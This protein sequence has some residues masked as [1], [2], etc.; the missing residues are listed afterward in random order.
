MLSLLPLLLAAL[1]LSPGLACFLPSGQAG[2][3]GLDGNCYVCPAGSM[4]QD[5]VR[6]FCRTVDGE[7]QPYSGQTECLMS[8]VCTIEQY[9]QQKTTLRTPRICANLTHCDS[10]VSYVAVNATATTDRVCQCSDGHADSYPSCPPCPAGCA[11]CVLRAEGVACSLCAAALVL[12]NETC[13]PLPSQGFTIRENLGAVLAVSIVCVLLVAVTV[14]AVTVVRRRRISAAATA[15]AREQRRIP[16]D[17]FGQGP[18]Y[19]TVT[20]PLSAPPLPPPRAEA[21]YV[22]PTRMEMTH[23]YDLATETSIYDNTNTPDGDGYLDVCPTDE[24]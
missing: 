18:L 10:N 23:L 4:C 11:E 20:D 15:A 17:A 16:L 3:K 19:E 14:A 2:Y 22:E 6:A 24:I 1:T 5:G 8:P 7:Y 9:E 21:A 13:I 12:Q